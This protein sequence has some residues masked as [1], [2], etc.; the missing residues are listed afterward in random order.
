MRTSR[1]SIAKQDIQSLFDK[2]PNKI[3][4]RSEIEKVLS[5]NRGFW[6]VSIST[7]TNKFIDFLL[8]ATKLKL[9]KFQFPSRT[10][11]RYVWGEAPLFE[12][13]LSLA[14]NSFFTHYTAMYLHEL[15][16]QIPKTIYL[17]S[18]QPPKYLGNGDLIQERIDSAF[19]RPAR[20]SKN[21]ASYEGFKIFL[22]NGMFSGKLGVIDIIGPNGEKVPVTNIERTLIDITVR[23][24]YSGGVFEVL[25]AYRLAH[26][27][28]SINKLSA[29]LS[30]LNY[31]YPYFQAIG[32][33][34]D[35]AGLYKDSQIDLLRQAELKYDF[36]LTNQM[37]D[38]E[39]SKKWRLYFPKGL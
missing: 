35:R 38:V 17:N 27:K 1:L 8:E 39:Y 15:T 31:R 20:T 18:E 22:L 37:K 6:R 30:K 11:N 9:A 13:V 23:P 29:L 34:L 19:R 3:L 7:T 12:L 24:I 21:I 28:V 36:Y 5:L 25:K 14:P 26:S 33:Y 16:E 32:F 4:T 2:L 10:V